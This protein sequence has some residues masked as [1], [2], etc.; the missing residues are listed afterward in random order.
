MIAKRALVALILALPLPAMA[1]PEPYLTAEKL[2]LTLL[3]PPPPPAGGAVEKAEIEAVVAA[4]RGASAARIALGAH[5]AEEDV[6]TIFASAM[7]TDFTPAN[8]PI[9]TVFFARV[10]ESEDQTVDPSKKKFGRVRPWIASSDVKVLGP[11]TKSGS[12]PSGH[13]A[14]SSME[15]IFLAAMVPEKRE[16]IWARQAEY[17][18]SRIIIGM[19]Y[20]LD[21]VVGD[22]AGTAMAT[23]MFADAAFRADFDRAKTEVRKALGLGG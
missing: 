1:G 20:P 19:H 8:L 2:D 23:A 21:L 5:D 6:F 11:S 17:A 12:W 9:A 4:Q 16:A 10:G 13:A 3:L 22:R 18:Q 15:A 14:R 7:G